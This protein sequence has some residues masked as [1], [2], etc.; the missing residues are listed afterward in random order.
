MIRG[1]AH[2]IAPFDKIDSDTRLSKRCFKRRD[3]TSTYTHIHHLKLPPSFGIFITHLALNVGG[4]ECLY[5][6]GQRST[7]KVIT[8]H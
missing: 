7:T 4:T 6:P 2:S 1:A 8:P 3:N 5:R